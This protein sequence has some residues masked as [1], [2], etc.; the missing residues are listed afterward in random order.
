MTALNSLYFGIFQI[1]TFFSKIL[2]F[3]RY[4]YWANEKQL[5]T[6]YKLFKTSKDNVPPP[7]FVNFMNE[8]VLNNK[9]VDFEQGDLNTV[10]VNGVEVHY[11]VCN[12]SVLSLPNNIPGVAF[13]LAIMDVPYGLQQE[14]WDEEVSVS[15]GFFTAST[16]FRVNSKMLNIFC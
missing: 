14:S 5:Q 4:P 6:F 8:N 13:S 12:Q 11:S 9:K 3:L 10:E 16:C 15:F 1:L 7:R 2:S